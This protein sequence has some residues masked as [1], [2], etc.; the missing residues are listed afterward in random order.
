MWFLEICLNLLLIWIYNKLIAQ[1]RC[2]VFWNLRKSSITIP[3]ELHEKLAR[4]SQ[5]YSRG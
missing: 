2:P 3:V 5:A 1:R 4:T